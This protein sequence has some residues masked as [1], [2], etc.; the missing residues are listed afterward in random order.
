MANTKISDIASAIRQNPAECIVV[1]GQAAS[2]VYPGQYVV[3]VGGEWTLADADNES[4]QNLR[5]GLV[6]FRARKDN[7]GADKDIDDAYDIDNEPFLAMI[8]VMTSGVGA[9]FITDQGETVRAGNP[10]QISSTAGSL[11]RA[12]GNTGTGTDLQQYPVGTL[13]RKVASGDTVGFVDLD[14]KGRVV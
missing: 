8:G 3:N 5:G 2:D 7:D 13:A 12:K 6:I 11:T 14:S 4:H 10:M 1:D 9:C